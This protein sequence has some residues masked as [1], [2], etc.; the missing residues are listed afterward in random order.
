M[1]VGF[2]P[3]KGNK[4]QKNECYH[5]VVIPVHIPN[6]DGYY[7]E[8]LQILKLCIESLIKT[9]HTKTFIS[10]I[11]NGSCIAVKEYLST[12]L[13]E[14]KIDELIQTEAIGKVNAVLKGLVGHNFKLV[15]ITDADVLFLNNWQEETYKIF[16]S[17]RKTGVV[18]TTP[19]SKSY[20]TLVSNLYWDTFFSNRLK[21]RN[22]KNPEALKA[23]ANSIGHD[24]FYNGP[25]LQS[26]LTV[27]KGNDIAVVGAGHF[28]ATYRG[29]IFRSL[30]STYSEYSLGAN[31]LH[32]LLDKPVVKK[33]YWRLSTEDN[34][35]YHMGNTMEPWMQ[36]E[37]DGI[38]PKENNI[39][40]PKLSEDRA[41]KS[42]SYLVKNTFFSKFITNKMIMRRFFIWKGLSKLNAK[43]YLNW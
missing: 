9:S 1:R 24:D 10:V 40:Q 7:K 8:G 41:Y 11:D 6:L 2:N 39:V 34:Y 21:F 31:S 23:F 25:Q 15:T 16:T 27:N 13:Q 33:G 4:I 28:A 35:T 36:L 5:Q 43:E 26:Y 17:F 22:V 37:V 38:K 29:D 30:D 19:S 42:L 12:L 32:E 18:C 3:N 14:S 20:K